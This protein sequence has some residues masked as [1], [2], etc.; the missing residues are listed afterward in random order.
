MKEIQAQAMIVTYL[1]SHE[2]KTD[3]PIPVENGE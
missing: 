3:D 2:R 1:S